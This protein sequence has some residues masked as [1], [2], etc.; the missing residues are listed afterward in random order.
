MKEIEKSSTT[1]PKLTLSTLKLP[2]YAT[3]VQAQLLMSLVSLEDRRSL[4]R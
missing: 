1:T 3:L 2:G 4:S